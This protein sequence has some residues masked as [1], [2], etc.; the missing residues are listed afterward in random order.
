T[1]GIFQAAYEGSPMSSFV[2]LGYGG[3]GPIEATY[4]YGRGKWVNV[5][6]DPVTGA[7]TLGTPYNRRTPWYTQTDFNVSHAFKI[8]E[9]SSLE[10][11]STFTNLLN[12]HAPVSYWQGFASNFAPT[13][14]FPYQIFGGASFYQT[15]ETGYDPQAA[16]NDAGL[17]KNSR[18]GKPN[19]WQLSRAIRFGVKFTF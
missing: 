1:F 18:Y 11:S 10:F 3:S 5:T 2:D 14:L 13:F 19:L 15:V 16:A 12:Q 9:R 17:I 7:V 8:K 6:S 4:I